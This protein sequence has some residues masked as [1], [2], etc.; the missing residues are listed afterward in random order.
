MKK[1]LVSLGI[2]ITLFV[3]VHGTKACESQLDHPVN[4]AEII[5]VEK[6]VKDVIYQDGWYYLITEKDVDGGQ[7]VLDVLPDRGENPSTMRKLKNEYI[8]KLVDVQYV[9]EY[10]LMSWYPTEGYAE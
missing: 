6:T 9:G 4:P 7:W 1:F 5:I 10:E 8:G 2:A 3:G